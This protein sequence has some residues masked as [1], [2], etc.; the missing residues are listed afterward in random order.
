MG[1]SPLR[2]VFEATEI[3]VVPELDREKD[4]PNEKQFRERMDQAAI[5]TAIWKHIYQVWLERNLARHGK[6]EE[7]KRDHEVSFVLK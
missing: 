4:K 1:S 5:T 7:E 2:E 3:D 6:E